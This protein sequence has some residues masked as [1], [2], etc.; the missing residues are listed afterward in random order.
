MIFTGR[1]GQACAQAAP[2][3]R[4]SSRAPARA[5]PRRRVRQ[6]SGVRCIGSLQGG[7][8]LSTA[9]DRRPRGLSRSRAIRAA[10]SRGLRGQAAGPGRTA[11]ITA[12]GWSRCGECP[13]S[14]SSSTCVCGTRRAM[15]RIC[16]SVPYSSSRPCTASSGQ[17]MA[18]ISCSIDQARNGGPQ[19]GVVPA[20]EGR[21]GVVVVPG[22]ALAQ[23]GVGVGLARLGDAGHRHV[24]DPDVR[25]QHH[26]AGQRLREARGVQQR[27]RRAVAVAEQPGPVDRGVDAQRAQ[28]RRQHLVRLVVHEVGA[29]G[30]ARRARRAAAVAGARI[31]QAARSPARRT[32][33]PG[34]RATSTPSPG[35]R[36]GTPAAAGRCARGAASWC[37][38]RSVRPAASMSTNPV[39]TVSGPALP[40]RAA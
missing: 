6:R 13:Q 5:R 36:A 12:S 22:Q 40:G 25:R 10:R 24:L 14:G 17:V 15:P 31:H 2:V 3:G 8:A 28:Q 39:S 19:P 38:M 18:A 26:G 35:L 7:P 21:I 30:L 16:S 27:D 32:A 20:E 37:S 4:A 29:P 11:S 33:A 9:G 1:P 34:S 23:V